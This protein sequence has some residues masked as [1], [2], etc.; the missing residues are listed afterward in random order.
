MTADESKRSQAGAMRWTLPRTVSFWML[1]GLLVLLL[2]AASA[3]SPLY[4]VYQGMFRF[5]AI[6]LTAIYASYAFGGIA[7]LLLTGRLSD[8]LGRR[9][10][11]LFA[12]LLDVASMLCFVVATDV[13]M[14]FVGRTLTGIA[15]GIAAG[16]VSA[17]LLDLQ[18]PS[19][20]RLGSLLTGVSTLLGLGLG[21]FG[22]G[23]LVQYGPDPLHLVFWLLAGLYAAS[24]M[25]VLAM[26]DPVERRPGWLGSM[27]PMVG[28]P[29][30]ARPLFVA[31]AP[32]LVGMWALAGL[33]LSLGPSL[34]ISI[35][36]AESRIA[37][38]LVILALTGTGAVASVVAQRADASL[39]LLRGCV[40]LLAGVGLTLIG[41]W[42]ES[43]AVLYAGSLLAGLGL[44]PAFSAFLRI[45]TPLASAERRG[46]LVGAIYVV[47]YLSFSVPAVIGGAAAT[48]FGLRST[49]FGYGLVVIGLAG[50]TTIAVSR[51]MARVHAAEARAEIG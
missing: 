22:S 30:S 46:A 48:A 34:A 26:P 19:N 18:P 38:G 3:P 44:G 15:T 20:P 16:V 10:V 41:V 21:A 51:R 4:G 45:I 5:P 12:L 24:A 2:F 35:L 6:T 43:A 33:Y 13:A 17:W 36:H 1:A 42:A 23:L 39:T 25:V 8:H 37:G 9:P 11:L 40:V 28:V 7:A 14:L 31:S 47:T 50:A 29:P 27:R 32:A 49:T